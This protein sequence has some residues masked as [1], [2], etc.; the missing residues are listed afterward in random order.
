MNEEQLALAMIYLHF[1]VY[2]FLRSAGTLAASIRLAEESNFR[3]S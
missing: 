3:Q 1:L 2:L